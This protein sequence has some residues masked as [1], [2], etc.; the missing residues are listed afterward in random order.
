MS[1]SPTGS[2]STAEAV[3][4]CPFCPLLCDRFHPQPRLGGGWQLQGSDC[5]LAQAGLEEAASHDAATPQ[6]D[7]QPAALGAALAEAAR[8]LRASRQPLLGG[9][10]TDVAGARALHALAHSLGAIS[11]AAGGAALMQAVRVLQDRGG[12]TT[13]LAEVRER[14][15]LIVFVGSWPLPRAPELLSRMTAG[16]AGAPPQLVALMPSPGTPGAAQGGAASADVTPQVP[17]EAAGLPVSR[18]ALG[19][20]LD[21]AAAVQQLTALVAGRTVRGPAPALQAL[22]A[23]LQAAQY[24]VLVWEPAQ[25]GGHAGLLIERLQQLVGL[26]NARGRAAGFPVGGGLGAATANQV[27]A[28]RGGLPLRSRRGP[29]GQEHEPLALDGE[30]LLADSAVDA[31]IWVVSYRVAT[32]PTLAG[33]PRIVLG[34]PA[35]AGQLGEPRNTIFI[36]VGTPGVHHTGHLFRTDGVVM[37]PLH[38]LPERHL[39]SVAEV[40]TQLQQALA[41]TEVAA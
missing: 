25:L 23:Q 5:A 4:T 39:P 17:A 35:L 1:L 12:Y 6:I 15:D 34:L 3:W 18:L 9:L 26:L 14:A 11:D 31:L 28:W 27:Y 13:T 33:G 32:V 8:R 2:S 38:A 22:A 7:G 24:A 19:P 29:W 21:L 36:P 41:L 16:R 20:D 40:A 10:G 37:L 30:R